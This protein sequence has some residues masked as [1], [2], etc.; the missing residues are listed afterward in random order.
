MRAT[1][2]HIFQTFFVDA[3]A[4][5]VAVVVGFFIAGIS[6]KFRL[7][8]LKMMRWPTVE[9]IVF[10]SFASPIFPVHGNNCVQMD[11]NEPRAKAFRCSKY[12][13]NWHRE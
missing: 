7:C 8:V 4:V 6:V 9:Y 3:D 13:T 2:A 5:V 11:E 10:I 12:Q 1:L